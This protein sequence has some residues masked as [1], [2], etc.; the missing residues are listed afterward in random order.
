MK[1]LSNAEVAMVSGANNQVIA[2]NEH[3]SGTKVIVG[4]G[5]G[6]GIGIGPFI[7]GGG[8]AIIRTFTLGGRR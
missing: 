6:T 8:V 5:I 2:A 4:V 3:S 7:I 1:Q